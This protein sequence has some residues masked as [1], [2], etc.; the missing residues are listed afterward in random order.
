KTY[1]TMRV[2][3]FAGLAVTSLFLMSI[4]SPV[5]ARRTLCEKKL[6]MLWNNFIDT[7]N[8]RHWSTLQ[9][10]ILAEQFTYASGHG[11]VP[12][13]QGSANSTAYFKRLAAENYTMAITLDF[14]SKG[15][16][17]LVGGGVLVFT[18]KDGIKMA[19]RSM[20]VFKKYK[21]NQWKM[22]RSIDTKVAELTTG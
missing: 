19:F 3:T 8:D 20:V 7:F 5:E 18:N 2:A 9:H 12:Y 17:L 10:E 21:Y 1:N 22:Y 11:G 4:N 13:I 16:K 14:C 15:T 6:S